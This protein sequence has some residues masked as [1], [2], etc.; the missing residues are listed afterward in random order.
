MN[1]IYYYINILKEMNVKTWILVLF[2]FMVSTASADISVSGTGTISA[3]PDVAYISVGVV[4]ENAD[5]GK[6]LAENNSRMERAFKLLDERGIKKSELQTSRFSIE[7]RFLNPK[8]GD[9]GGVKLSGYVV[10]N[11]L[12]V[13]VYDKSLVG[14]I[15]NDLTKDGVNRIDGIVFGIRDRE[16]LQDKARLLAIQDAR[17]KAE[18]MAAALDITVGKVKE[19]SEGGFRPMPEMT[20]QARMLDASSTPVAEGEKKIVS[21]VHVVFEVGK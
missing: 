8:S 18:Q 2:G 4:T 17:K 10:T 14:Q 7:P 19:V 21:Q 12:T 13:T 16:A 1:L 15:I 6:A 3:T 11:Q 9:Q 20:Y 5:A